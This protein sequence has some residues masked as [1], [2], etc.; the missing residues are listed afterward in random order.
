MLLTCTP[1]DRSEQQD[2]QQA[3]ADK[4]C[5]CKPPQYKGVTACVPYA[6]PFAYG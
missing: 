2:G 4:H 3:I 1:A 5:E 6:V